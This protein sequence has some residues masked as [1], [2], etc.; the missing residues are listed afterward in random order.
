MEETL[1]W[2]FE[3]VRVQNF[4]SAFIHL[5]YTTIQN[6][7]GTNEIAPHITLQLVKNEEE[8]IDVVLSPLDARLVARQ[9]SKF[10]RKSI[11][12]AREKGLKYE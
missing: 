8:S 11:T 9:L 2:D 6:K 3:D 5:S 1:F 7:K 10:A 4:P 12:Y